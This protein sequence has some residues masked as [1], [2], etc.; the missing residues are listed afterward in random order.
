[1]SPRNRYQI[2]RR[3]P[4]KT[5]I[6]YVSTMNQQAVNLTEPAKSSHSVQPAGLGIPSPTPSGIARRRKNYALSNLNSSCASFVNSN[7][8]SLVQLYVWNGVFGGRGGNCNRFKADMYY[9]I[10]V[11]GPVRAPR[12]LQ[13]SVVDTCVR[14]ERFSYADSHGEK[15]A[16]FSQRVGVA[17]S[18]L[19]AWNKILKPDRKRFL[20]DEYYCVAT[21]E[22]REYETGTNKIA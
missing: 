16:A 12:Y 19:Y 2:L 20:P 5:K 11:L 17:L 1:V 9:C 10:G 8:F 21:A 4:E 3:V 6:V 14:Y 18:D 22:S 15:C 13:R 7:S